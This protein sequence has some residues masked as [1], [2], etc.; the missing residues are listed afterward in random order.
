MMELW[1]ICQR[2]ASCDPRTSCPVARVEIDSENLDVL[3]KYLLKVNE[4][5]FKKASYNKWFKSRCNLE[6]L[7]FRILRTA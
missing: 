5:A 3:E 2:T 1:I 6:T 7:P 4:I